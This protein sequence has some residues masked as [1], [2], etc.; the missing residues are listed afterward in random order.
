[1]QTLT[2][3]LG[4]GGIAGGIVMLLGILYLSVLFIQGMLWVGA[5]CNTAAVGGDTGELPKFDE[6]DEVI[7]PR[8]ETR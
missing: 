4:S 3:G 2:A 5:P 6:N 8:K 1:M 7:K